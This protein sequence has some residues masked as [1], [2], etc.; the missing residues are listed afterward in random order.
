MEKTKNKNNKKV[1]GKKKSFSFNF[2][3]IKT[4]LSNFFRKLKRSH[5]EMS[6]MFK[7]KKDGFNN[8]VSVL[9]KK[10]ADQPSI[11]EKQPIKK[12]KK[13]KASY[14][15]G[16]GKEK[17]YFVEMLSML[18]NSGMDI[19]IALESIRQEMK[20]KQLKR[21]VLEIKESVEAGSPIWKALGESKM[22]PAQVV[23]MIQIGEESG[24]LADNLLVIALQQKKEKMFKSKVKSALIYPVIVIV[25]AIVIALGISWFILPR[26]VPIFTSLSTD[27]PFLTRV[28]ALVGQLF[29]DWGFIIVPGGIILTFIIV[30][31]L[32]IFTPTKK[33]G[34]W[35]L[36]HIPITKK[37]VQEV[38]LSRLGYTLGNLLKVG[39]SIEAAFDSLIKS[40][41][42]YNFKNYYKYLRDEVVAGESFLKSFKYSKKTKKLIPPTIQEM[43]GAGEQSGRLSETLFAVGEIYEQ[44]TEITAKNLATTIEPIIL[45]VIGVVI[46]AIALSVIVPIYGLLDVF[47]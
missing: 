12:E 39:L 32:F 1:L 24:T 21:I 11:K 25:L 42:Y 13:K 18:L 36:Y 15:F 4:P 30:F 44:K 7:R 33:S 26:L 14:Q 22:L 8:K 35:I 10:S 37:L 31:F 20:N 16:L 38:E 23:S 40:T 27:V 17:E 47:E 5:V 9:K 46:M 43:V 41:N 45:I 28:L 34:Q 6:G 29:K 2:N 19:S 3:W